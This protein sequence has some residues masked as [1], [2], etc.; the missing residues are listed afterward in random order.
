[1]TKGRLVFILVAVF[2][3]LLLA[4]AASFFLLDFNRPPSIAP[5]SYLEIVLEGP[6]VEFS[7]GNPLAS[8]LGV[9][10]LSVHDIWTG[11]RKARVDDRIAGVLLRLGPLACDW[12]KCAEVRDEVAAFR[13]SGKKAYAYIEEAASFDKEY[14]LA[15]A[16]D[17]IF[18]HPLGWFGIAGIGGD[19]PFLKT[20]LDKLGIEAQIVHVEQY[21][22]AYDMFTERGFTPAHREMME[23]LISDEF[24][25]YIK[26]VAAARHK[27]EADVRALIDEAF[28]Q[29]DRAVASGL[30]D[31]L[32]FDDQVRA[33]F[34]RG[35]SRVPLNVYTR[36]DPASLGLGTGRKVALIY[37]AGA[38]HGGESAYQSMG[39]D[40]V[41]RSLRAARED[42]SVAAV[43]FRVDSP[44][45]S[46][47]ASDSIWREVM[48]CREKKPFVV[49]MSDVAGSG[50]YW[51]SMA[52]HKIV[53][54]PQTLT[55]SIGVLSGKISLEKLMAKVGIA[56]EKVGIGQRL[57]VFSPFRS[58]TAEE[59]QLL[60]KQILW[61]YDR[62]LAKVAESRGLSKETVDG[63]G[64]GRVWTG[65][66]AKNLHLVDELGGLSRAIE[67][68]KELAG[69]P[70]SEDVRF[71]VWPRRES[72]F[73]TLFRPNESRFPGALSK[74]V[75]A[76]SEWA[77]RLNEDRV[78]AVMPILPGLG[79]TTISS[80]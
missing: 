3:V 42:R 62:F 51:I 59:T 19:V 14:Y 49:S 80:F 20:A 5:A 39:A 23:S 64:K 47:V 6:L 29:G 57:G 46:A 61:I 75:R 43:V 72:L 76:A 68:A 8:F 31:G 60:K 56:T 17:K 2:A 78:W 48:L 21:K 22:T 79:G 26:T 27:S 63:I 7:G 25:Y 18:L 32:L 74:E 34:G 15:T 55:G 35:A 66:Q 30:V 69:I 52:A 45:G 9:R 13:A 73:R 53:A 65:G 10:P 36:I 67:L 33:L 11:L 37:A 1:M 28:F 77:A 12:A 4:T 54:Q 38:I 24:A 58:M 16:C 41:V 70:T 44:G 50:G 40:T 71:V